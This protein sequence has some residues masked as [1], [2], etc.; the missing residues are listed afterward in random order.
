MQVVTSAKQS[1]LGILSHHLHLPLV[2]VLHGLGAWACTVAI[3]L[4]FI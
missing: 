2:N 1:Q 4:F 3:I